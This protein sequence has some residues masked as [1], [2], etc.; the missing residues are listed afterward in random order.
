M[1]SYNSLFFQDR[2]RV[3]QLIM[4]LPFIIKPDIDGGGMTVPA[5]GLPNTALLK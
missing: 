2:N 4:F 5:S 1:V 3:Q